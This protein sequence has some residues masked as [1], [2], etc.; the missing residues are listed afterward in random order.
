[1]LLPDE[2]RR[3]GDGRLQRTI[4]GAAVG[5]EP[6]DSFG[7]FALI[8][9]RAQAQTDMDAANDEDVVFGFDLAGGFPDE[10][11]LSRRYSARFQRAGKSARQSTGGAGHHVIEGGGVGGEGVGRDLVVRG[12]GA[13]YTKG[14]RLRLRREERL[15]DRPFLPFD[16]HVGTVDHF[17]H[18][19]SPSAARRLYRLWQPNRLELRP[20]E[21]D[22]PG[23]EGS[24]VLAV[25]YNYRKGSR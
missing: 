4:D 16:P 24:G 23:C 2:F 17:S 19:D 22:R 1:M 8:R 18:E 7:G 12:D 5:E 3:E 11:F 20:I 9:L 21:R 10:P 25:W 13:V 6:V 15:A 14:H